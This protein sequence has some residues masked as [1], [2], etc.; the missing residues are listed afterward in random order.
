MS[1]A[2]SWPLV[3]LRSE[4]CDNQL[5]VIETV[6]GPGVSPPLHSHDFDETFYLMEGE[7]VFRLRARAHGRRLPGHRA[8][9]V[10]KQLL[11]VVTTLGPPSDPT[12]RPTSR[13]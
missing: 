4:E 6:A 11:P 5:S 13:K 8:T 7:L 9:G 3:L 10:A 12:Q 2:S 1:A